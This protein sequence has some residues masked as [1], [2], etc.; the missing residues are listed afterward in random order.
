VRRR[1]CRCPADH[2]AAPRCG[3]ADWCGLA[4]KTSPQQSQHAA[5]WPAESSA[6]QAPHCEQMH[7]LGFY[8]QFAA[9]LQ[10]H[11]TLDSRIMPEACALQR[12][13]ASM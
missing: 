7:Q 9:V 13:Q 11:D 6:A 10:R 5:A 4:A 2:A 3:R 8:Q 1:S 12:K